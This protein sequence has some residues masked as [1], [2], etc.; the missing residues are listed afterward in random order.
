MPSD[1]PGIRITAC[2]AT[3]I[4]WDAQIKAFNSNTNK[5]SKHNSTRT[6]IFVTSLTTRRTENGFTNNMVVFSQVATAKSSKHTEEKMNKRQKKA[7][8]SK[9]SLI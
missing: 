3:F 8:N 9:L 6:Q 5:K 7:L 4:T 2:S 1:S